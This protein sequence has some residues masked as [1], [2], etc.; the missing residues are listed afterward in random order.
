[1]LIKE[2]IK[3][4][5]KSVI[6]Y[7]IFTIMMFITISLKANYYI[8]EIYSYGLS[9]FTGDGIDMKIEFC[10]TYAPAASAYWD[11]MVVQQG[12]Q[13]D[14]ASVWSNQT[15]DVHPPLYYA[16]LHTISSIRPNSFSRWHAGMIN[17]LSALLVLFVMRRLIRLLTDQPYIREILSVSFIFMTGI[18]SAVTYF[19]MYLAAMLLVTLLTYLFLKQVDEKHQFKFYAGIFLVTVAG[20]LTHYYIIVYAALISCVYGI[21]LLWNKRIKET[22][23]FC[24]AMALAAIASVAVFPAMIEHMFFGYR[25][26]EAIDNLADNMNYWE[27]LK[28]FFNLINKQMFGNMLGYL[29]LGLIILFAIR[30]AKNGMGAFEELGGDAISFGFERKAVIRYALILI[31]CFLYFM[32]ISKM[33][34]TASDRYLTPIYAVF[35]V[36]V[37]SVTYAVFKYFSGRKTFVGISVV[38]TALLIG[39]SYASSEWPYLFRDSQDFLAEAE[40]HGNYDCICILGGDSYMLYPEFAEYTNYKSITFLT[41]EDLEKEGIGQWA[42]PEGVLISFIGAVADTDHAANMLK[43]E[44]G[45]ANVIKLGSFGYDNTYFLSN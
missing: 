43:E 1:M 30:Y 21:F 18:L 45:Y 13:F 12:E 22:L 16:I 11:Y 38:M 32:I 6:L 44:H 39:G 33:T 25:G 5:P 31:P 37:M 4:I 20:A 3:A 9:N 10:K 19:R 35:F 14:Y 17:I 40:A 7:I 41:A 2:K 15:Y 42:S 8:D 23:G 27:A 26:T 36:G 28:A 29:I 24:A 34:F